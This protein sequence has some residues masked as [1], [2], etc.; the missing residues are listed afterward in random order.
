MFW[1]LRFS[2][3]CRGLAEDIYYNR[4]RMWRWVT[5]RVRYSQAS[6]IVISVFKQSV[7]TPVLRLLRQISN[8]TIEILN[9]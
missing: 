8:Y 7:K 3:F 2:I 5:V 1:V 9:A 6:L 4:P